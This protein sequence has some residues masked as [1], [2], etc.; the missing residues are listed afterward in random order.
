[1]ILSDIRR[2][3]QTREQASLADLALHFDTDVDAMRGML[4]VWVRKGMIER[5]LATAS[6][7]SSCTRCDAAATEVYTWL[8]ESRSAGETSASQSGCVQPFPF[9]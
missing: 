5:R 7:G 6:C 9:K 8:G 3:L 2:Y 4:Q 1:M